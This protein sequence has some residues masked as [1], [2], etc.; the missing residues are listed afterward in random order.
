MDGCWLDKSWWL[1]V[2]DDGR[3][4]RP[5]GA[6]MTGRDSWRWQAHHRCQW[7]LPIQAPLLLVPDAGSRAVRPACWWVVHGEGRA[8][9]GDPLAA[10]AR[11]TH[12]ISSAPGVPATARM[13]QWLAAAALQQQGLCGMQ[14]SAAKS[15]V[16][17]VPQ[18]GTLPA[19][20][21]RTARRDERRRRRYCRRCGALAAAAAGVPAAA[22]P[23]A[24]R[25]CRLCSQAMTSSSDAPC[26]GSLSR[27][28]TRSITSASSLPR[29]GSIT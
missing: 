6:A 2:V 22:A 14:R 24:R 9:P 7:R 1:V 15:H 21:Q 8:P 26:C 12:T 11:H 18:A 27:R 29:C 5:Q 10:P 4:H 20:R 19:Q 17:C 23:A 28:Y 13:G 16:R 25:C 3:R